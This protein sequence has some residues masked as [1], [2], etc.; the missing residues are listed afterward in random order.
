M[1][2]LTP[3]SELLTRMT[4]RY[5]NGEIPWHHELPPPEVIALA[6][7]C[8]P[9]KKAIKRLSMIS[10]LPTTALRISAFIDL[11]TL[12]TYSACSSIGAGP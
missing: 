11:K 2:N 8:P 7:A 5:A 1:T 6:E 4:E 9:P 12:A 3:P 10:S